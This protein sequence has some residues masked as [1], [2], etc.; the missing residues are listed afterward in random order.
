MKAVWQAEMDWFRDA[1]AVQS[2]ST[3]PADAGARKAAA[4]VIRPRASPARSG[5]SARC[6]GKR[7]PGRMSNTTCGQFR[8]GNQEMKVK[9][10]EDLS[11]ACPGRGREPLNL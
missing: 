4:G 9:V 2:G 6:S 7:I 11:N 5:S 3:I 8:S 10:R 1:D